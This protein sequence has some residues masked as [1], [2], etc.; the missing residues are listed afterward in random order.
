MCINRLQIPCVIVY[1]VLHILITIC[2][3]SRIASMDDFA[4]D[5]M[6]DGQICHPVSRLLDRLLLKY[7]RRLRPHYGGPPVVVNVTMNIDSVGPISEVDMNF[8]IDISFRQYWMDRRLMFNASEGID[9]LTV[10][11]NFLSNIWQPDTYFPDSYESKKQEVMVP[12]I[13]LRIKPDGLV[14]YSARVTVIA[15]CPMDLKYFPMDIQ[16]CSLMVETFGYTSKD[17]ILRWKN[18]DPDHKP[19]EFNRQKLE[20]A[21]F[22]LIDLVTKQYFLNFSTGTFSDLEVVFY[23]KRDLIYFIIQ[24]YVPATLIVL[25]SWVNFYVNRHS[26]PARA[27]LAITTVLTMITLMGAT[28]SNLP[29]VS[30]IK[31]L[32]IYFGICFLYVFGALVEFALVC[33]FN[34]PRYQPKV[35][36]PPE[37]DDPALVGVPWRNESSRIQSNGLCMIE[38]NIPGGGVSSGGH[39]HHHQQQHPQ[40]HHHHH[41]S[42]SRHSPKGSF[43]QTQPLLCNSHSNRSLSVSHNCNEMTTDM[44]M[45]H[46]GPGSPPSPLP[47]ARSR[48]QVSTSSIGGGGGGGHNL[49]PNEISHSNMGGG[50]THH[51][52]LHHSLSNPLSRAPSFTTPTTPNEYKSSSVAP[53]S[54]VLGSKPMFET[55]YK[56]ASHPSG[57]MNCE[58]TPSGFFQQIPRQRNPRRRRGKHVPKTR[59]IDVSRID[60]YSRIMFPLTYIMICLV[61]WMVYLGVTNLQD[62]TALK[63]NTGVQNSP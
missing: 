30:S 55:I 62:R 26:V 25:L 17:L 54:P 27:S 34:K 35:S 2:D 45:T 9:A 53:Q 46:Y 13:L 29:R 56:P 38:Q 23:F 51:P 57:H 61:Y 16:K 49:D 28:N 58:T 33:Y 39:H 1:Q 6:Q 18:D 24:T 31:A 19:V 10:N 21:Q 7:D 3:C 41:S 48:K 43:S 37:R 44:G 20:L 11:S 14:L 36:A 22:K 5:P 50:G 8:R 42:S 52:L 32:D 40:Y 12:N 59:S 47:I 63:N 60:L 15:K 4:C